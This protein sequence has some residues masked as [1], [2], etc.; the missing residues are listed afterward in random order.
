[1]F[2]HRLH[3][4]LLDNEE[5]EDDEAVE[6]IKGVN[7][8]DGQ[9]LGATKGASDGVGQPGNPGDEEQPDHDGQALLGP[10]LQPEQ[11][12]Y[13]DTIALEFYNKITVKW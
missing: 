13:W 5:K 10:L 9:V 12:D 7:E 4:W 1:M 3:N 11:Q 8:E 6:C 2:S